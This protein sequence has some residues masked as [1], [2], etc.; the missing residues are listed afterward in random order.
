MSAA[1]ATPRL[2]LLRPITIVRNIPMG[3]YE[4]T[5]YTDRANIFA[6]MKE[7]A[8]ADKRRAW[9]QIGDQEDAVLA[10]SYWDDTRMEQMIDLTRFDADAEDETGFGWSLTGLA[11]LVQPTT[12]TSSVSEAE[13]PAVEA[14]EPEFIPVPGYPNLVSTLCACGRSAF[15]SSLLDSARESHARHVARPDDGSYRDAETTALLFKRTP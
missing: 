2:D 9:E 11:F 6:L 12:P 8:A 1:D 13:I 10:Y 15:G 7:W 5:L 3:L 14:H 4:E